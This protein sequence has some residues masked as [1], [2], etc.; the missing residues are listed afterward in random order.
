MIRNPK[1]KLSFYQWYDKN[2]E[3]LRKKPAEVIAAY[4]RKNVDDKFSV[5]GMARWV[6]QIR[7]GEWN[8]NEL[9][10]ED[11]FSFTPSPSTQGSVSFEVADF[12]NPL[13][14]PIDFPE[15]WSE[16]NEP[17]EITGITRLGICS[18]IHLPYHDRYAVQA[19]MAEFKRREVNG[20]YLNGDIMDL[21]DVSSFVKNPTSTFLKDE[22][23]VGRQFLKSLRKMFPNIPIYFKD[24][25]HERR[26]ETYIATRCPEL[27]Q[28]IGM[29]MRTQLELDSLDIIHVPEQKVAKFGK[30]WI[31]HGHELGLKSGTL[32]I[33]RQVRMRV[34]VNIVFG[35]WHKQQNDSS[36]NLADEVHAS[37]ALGCLCYLKPRYTGVLNQWTQGAATVQLHDDGQ[38]FTVSAFQI[39][40]GSV[41]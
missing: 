2:K 41:I 32:N 12:T 5:L 18:D 36:R 15:S 33:A 30:L 27:A 7:R 39:Q 24:G 40:D 13:S 14:E 25:N 22:I 29:D 20:I 35:H 26:L 16:V 23:E 34:G 8:M 9:S 17:I 10:G 3:D 31:A 19:C 6:Q 1:E 11:G 38:S 21:E 37:W 28:M 4:Y